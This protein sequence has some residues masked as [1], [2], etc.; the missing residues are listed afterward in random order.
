M[1]SGG[2]RLRRGA[3]D[4]F[5]RIRANIWSVAQTAVAASAAYFLAYYLLGHERPF[6]APIAAVITLS[7]TL[8]Q[9]GRRT[10]ELVLGVA[11]GLMVADALVFLIG[12]GAVMIGAVVFLA[13]AAALLF[14]GGVLL[15]NQAAISAILVVV[16]QPP[17]TLFNPARF[18]DALMGGAV[19]LVVNYA[20]PA[21]PERV[22]ENA[23]R[24]VLDEL[25]GVLE[26][27]A[28]SLRNG[29]L[30]RSEA[31]LSKSRSIDDEVRGFM[32]AVSAGYETARLSPTRRRTLKHIELYSAAGGRIELAVLNTRV[33]ARGA[34]NA[35]RRGDDIPPSLPESVFDLAE[36]VRFLAVFLERNDEPEEARRHALKAAERATTLLKDRHD[37]AISVLVGQVR[38]AAVDILRST[39]M[40]QA[41]ALEAL[42]EAAG[43][44][45]EI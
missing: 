32:E 4:G 24:R 5:A 29:D 11:I 30:P 2:A 22:V 34:Y 45:S 10:L 31:A 37:L 28:A 7:V 33:L 38:S 17:D 12:P 39:G 20:F 25:V 19:A 3:G 42:E 23:A 14:G 9:R 8:G 16:L 40:D 1:R 41:S 6:F 43:R 26:E 13:M 18:L 21:N 36:S 15:V 44:A 35:V 27:V